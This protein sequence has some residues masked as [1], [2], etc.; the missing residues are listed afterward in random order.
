[1]RR[2]LHIQRL[3]REIFV[4]KTK[5]RRQHIYLYTLRRFLHSRLLFIMATS[6]EAQKQVKIRLS[7][8]DES[9]ALP[10]EVGELV[11][12]TGQWYCHMLARLIS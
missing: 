3:P 6:T 7:A 2:V 10:Q 5:H 4:S 8:K 11:I 9:I 12:S 1:M